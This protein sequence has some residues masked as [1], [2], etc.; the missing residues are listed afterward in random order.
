MTKRKP[1][2]P[3]LHNEPLERIEFYVTPEVAARIE[4][5]RGDEPRSSWIRRAI[6]EKLE[7]GK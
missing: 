7:E 1:G 5:A 6:L 4:T 3:P 2:R